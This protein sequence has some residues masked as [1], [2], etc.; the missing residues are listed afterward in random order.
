[1]VAEPVEWLTPSE[2]RVWR[3]LLSVEYRVR[4]RLDR[5]LRTGAGLTLGEYEVLVHLSEAP[6]RALRMSELAERLFLSQ[7]RPDPPHRRPGAGRPGGPPPCHD[8]GRGALAAL[9]PAG[10]GLL[11]Q[12]A[13]IHVAGVRRYLIGPLAASRRRGGAGWPGA[14]PGPGRAGARSG[15]RYRTGVDGPALLG[16]EGPSARPVP[17]HHGATPQPGRSPVTTAPPRSIQPLVPPAT[18]TARYPA[19][20][21]ALA[22]VRLRPPT[23]QIT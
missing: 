2:Q 17:R 22:A 15:C 20:T 23:A 19:S 6:E 16:D 10:L 14:G 7:E 9:T 12:A 13:P 18:D 4:E 3:R 5:E 8:D 21:R 1:M 11:E